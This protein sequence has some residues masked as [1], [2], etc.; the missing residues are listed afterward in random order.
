LT[1]PTM[2]C[3]KC[4]AQMNHQANKL[5]DA[6]TAAE[7]AAVTDVFDGVLVV[8]FAC[9]SCGW[10]DSRRETGEPTASA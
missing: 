7:A 2:T 4:G 3:P 6:V 1:R 10:I 8:V 9:P 5:V